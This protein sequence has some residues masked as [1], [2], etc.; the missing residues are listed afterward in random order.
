GQMRSRFVYPCQDGHVSVS[1][2]FGPVQGPYTHRLFEW[3]CEKGF[4]DAATR[5]KDWVN[6]LSLI[7]AKKERLSEMDR[8]TTAIEEFA[9]AHTKAEL[10]AEAERRRLLIV[11]V[12]TTADVARSE[13]LAARA[14]WTP[15]AMPESGETVA[16]PGPFARFGA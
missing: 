11:P 8:C 4:V 7:V 16:H 14:Y 12:S 2:M 3:M 6:Y 13:Q 9:R 15:V 1:F 5:D 10:I